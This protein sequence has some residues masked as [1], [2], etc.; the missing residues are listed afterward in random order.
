MGSTIYLFP[1]LKKIG[2]PWTRQ[3][4]NRLEKKGRFPRRF[5]LGDRQVAW[6]ADEV[7]RWLAGR[8]AE[9]GPQRAA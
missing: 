9:R 4:I 7:D 1:D 2:I 6:P 8:M 3:Y 5:R